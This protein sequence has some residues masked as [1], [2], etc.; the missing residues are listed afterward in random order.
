MNKKIFLIFCLFF[1]LILASS[2]GKVFAFPASSSE[3]YDGI[4]VSEW[5]GNINFSEVRASGIDIVY[6]KSSQG[7]SYIDPYFRSHYESAKQAG[8]NIGFYH[9]LTATTV[10]EAIEQAN[11]FISVINGLDCDCRLAMD[12]EVF[13]GLSVEEINNI[14]LEFLSE[15]QRLSG[16][17]VVIYSDAFNARNTFAERLSQQYPLW[18]AEYGVQEPSD[19]NWSTWIGFQY[20]NQGRISGIST[21]VDRDYFTSDIFLSDNSTIIVP[22]AP[23][24]VVTTD[25]VIVKRGD[26]LSQIAEI[27]NTSYQY[28]AKINDISN[29]NLIFVGE[30]IF[31][32][33]L[34]NSNLNDTS[35]VLYVV[36]RGNTL[37]QISMLY[38][39]SIESI[40]QLNDIENP[41]LIFSGE[42]LRIPVIN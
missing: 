14:S 12:F 30:K 19:G 11:F 40:V 38:G 13:D 3:I 31:V 10:N 8:L 42:V 26:T 29:P 21:F 33:R 9:F 28:L 34:D 17:E 22:S 25:F 39:V 32:P 20:T 37:T 5:Q 16:K 36:K 35:H 24:P 6:I 4:D 23:T 41:N 7:T 18:V 2:F 15:V 1:T 27:Y